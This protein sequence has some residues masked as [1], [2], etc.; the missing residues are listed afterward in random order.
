MSPVCRPTIPLPTS[1]ISHPTLDV[2]HPTVLPPKSHV[3][4]LKFDSGV[5]MLIHLFGDSLVFKIRV[6]QTRRRPPP[7]PPPLPPPLPPPAELPAP[8]PPAPPPI[9]EP[10]GWLSY[11]QWPTW[12]LLDVHRP[13]GGGPREAAGV[14]GEPL[15][16]GVGAAAPEVEGW[17][18]ALSMANYEAQEE[19]YD[20]WGWWAW[21][22]QSC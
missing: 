12:D 11:F 7:P 2:Q 19:L 3:P 5:R 18:V 17:E 15:R 22:P 10:Q 1:Q 6:T 4:R 16:P 14:E 21:S 8:V 20:C 9:A 13:T